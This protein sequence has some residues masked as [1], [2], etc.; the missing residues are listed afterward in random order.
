MAIAVLS[1]IKTYLG[2]TVSTYDTLLGYIQNGI[3]QYIK[4]ITGRSFEV[5][6]HTNELYDGSGGY[7]LRLNDAPLVIDSTHPLRCSVNIEDVIEIKN[8][9]TDMSTA[10]VIIDSSNVTLTVEGGTGNNSTV[11]AKA[12]Y[13]TLTL[14]VARINA[15]SAYGWSATIANSTYN[16]FQTSK[17]FDQVIELSNFGSIGGYEYIRMGDAV[18]VKANKTTGVIYCE[19]GFPRGWQN[20]V[21]SYYAGSAAPS[22]AVDIAIK[23]W[24]KS[25]WSQYNTDSESLK[26]YSI[27]ELEMEYFEYDAMSA[28]PSRVESFINSQIRYKV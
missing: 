20:I 17:L 4:D 16:S 15:L 6:A 22:K 28:M 21:V 23:D 26:R 14:L 18:N 12:T 2:I 11:N 3:E 10:Q 9:L 7:V 5:T 8:T 27:G 25:W 1:E 19:S 13:T 24:M